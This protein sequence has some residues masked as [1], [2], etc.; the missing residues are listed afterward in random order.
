MDRLLLDLIFFSFSLLLLLYSDLFGECLFSLV[1]YFRPHYYSDRTASG[2]LFVRV[3][4]T[5]D[6]H[7]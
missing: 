6:P 7:T 5:V 4:L 2:F 3:C 1:K